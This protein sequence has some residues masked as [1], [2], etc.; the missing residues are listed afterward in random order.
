MKHYNCFLYNVSRETQEGWNKMAAITPQT[1]IT[2]YANIP[3][4]N[5][6]V[7]TLYFESPTQQAQYFAQRRVTA[8]TGCTYQRQ[9]A[10]IR[11]SVPIKTLMNCNYLSFYNPNFEER[12]FYC[13]IKSVDYVNNECTEVSF[14]IDVI[15]TYWFDCTLHQCFIERGHTS[16][17]TIG[18]N[19]IPEGLETGEYVISSWTHT[20][21]L[22]PMCIVVAATVDEDGNPV[23][24]GYYSNVYSGV[25]LHVFREA[26]AVNQFLRKLTDLNKAD[27]VVNIFMQPYTFSTGAGEV[28]KRS[29]FN[30]TKPYSSISGYVPQNKKLFT[31][32]YNILTITNGEGISANF[33]Y[34]FFADNPCNFLVIGSMCTTPQAIC[35]PNKYKG[36]ESLNYDEKLVLDG[37][38]QC[39][40]N[41]DTYKAWLAQNANL[42]D[43][44]DN[45]SAMLL[46]N[47]DFRAGTATDSSILNLL[48]SAVTSAGAGAAL[49]AGV[50]SIIPGAGTAVGAGIGAIGGT[51]TGLASSAYN[52]WKQPVENT[53][54]IQSVQNQIDGILAAR[55]DHAT[56]PPQAVGGGSSTVMQGLGLK[57][58]FIY[59]KQITA[60]FAR[61]I[62]N[63]FQM[64]GY[65]QHKVAMPNI[66]ARTRFT[67]IKTKG[68]CITGN[69]PVW[70]VSAINKIFDNG[71][72]WWNDY[73][74]V[75]NYTFANPTIPGGE[76]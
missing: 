8:M 34:E 24:G 5:R 22:E 50:G 26:D 67:Y 46:R 15:Q 11:A 75:G 51:L 35:V 47:A 55:Q 60:E 4:D 2:F 53:I 66:H 45:T 33:H 13:F 61:I 72:T 64:Y 49:G 6:Y 56:T 73:V 36:T 74:G 16:D 68:S 62:D 63:Y 42:L 52:A 70:A 25:K 17:D 38:P 58:F 48:G 14:E 41:I 54:N 76:Y 71:I 3:L 39:A 59:Q 37:W 65:A 10:K 23:A 30:I 21:A 31:F 32:P 20:T 40:W 7:N 43:W 1:T 69:A 19:L 27:A 44:Q 29:E 9:T 28:P 18:K 12:T 57:T